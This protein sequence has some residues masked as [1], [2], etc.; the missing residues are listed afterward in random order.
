M[1][2]VV[3]CPPATKQEAEENE[4]RLKY[5]VYQLSE[6]MLDQIVDMWTSLNELGTFHETYVYVRFP[7][8][9]AMLV[10]SLSIGVNEASVGT[11]KFK[12]TVSYEGRHDTPRAVP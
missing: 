9:I 7:Y 2:M 12:A 6:F 5:I 11:H 1:S 3:V 10:K 8:Y 4:V